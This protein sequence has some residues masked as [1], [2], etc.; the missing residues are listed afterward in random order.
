MSQVA[1]KGEGTSDSGVYPVGARP[2]A[3]GGWGIVRANDRDEL[4]AVWLAEGAVVGTGGESTVTL[5]DEEVMPSHARIRVRADGAYV[6]AMSAEGGIWVDGVRAERMAV[7]HGNVVRMGSMVGVFVE[8]ELSA[9]CGKM[10]R[11]G[12]LVFG[13]RQRGWIE[14]ALGYVRAQESFLIEGSEGSGKAALA[15]AAVLSAAPGRTTVVVDARSPAAKA[16]VCDALASRTSSVLV[17]HLEQLERAA[18]IEAVRLLKRSAGTLLVGTLGRPLERALA[19]GL[20]APA[21][22]TVLA[23]RR[24]RV[25][26]LESRREDLVAISSALMER[27]GMDPGRLS[28]AVLEQ[29]MRGTWPG[30]IR[31]LREVLR[32]VVA[33]G[34]M[35]DDQRVRRVRERSTR[36]SMREPLALQQEDPDLARARLQ[37]ALDRAG[38]TIAAAARELHVSRQAFYREVK[39]LS[40]ELPHKKVHEASRM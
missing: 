40:V 16:S 24:V 6:E 37:R 23:S 17:L 4:T 35:T 22:A 31:E 33:S 39:R 38:G 15:Q 18:Q 21:V 14:T 3:A 30:G 2:A 1:L 12:D 36:A 8:R 29:L 27:E 10:G 5:V 28:V 26:S 32:E 9:H 13:P 20:L 19:D 11:L 25:P 34:E 7:A